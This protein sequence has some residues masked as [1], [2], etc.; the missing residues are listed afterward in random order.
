MDKKTIKLDR[1]E[2]EILKAI[3]RGEYVSA[4]M[5]KKEMN[6][7]RLAARNT[8]LKNK[9]ISIRISERDLLR[10]KA[11]AAEEGLPYQTLITST[12]HKLVR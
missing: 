12:L 6:A 9:T 4:P 1:D 10:L 7:L 11:R 5:S 8:L 2:R 3:D